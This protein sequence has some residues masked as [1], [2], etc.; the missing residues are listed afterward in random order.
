M[1]EKTKTKGGKTAP[2]DKS[3]FWIGFILI[4][5]ICVILAIF[6]EEAKGVLGK[7]FNFTTNQMGFTYIW[8]VIFMA[9][10]LVWLAFGKY[11]KVRMGGPDAR[12]EFSRLSWIAMFFCSGVADFLVIGFA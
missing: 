1:E 5:A 4:A 11:G 6:S 7:I 12:P 9:G 3:I 8:F 2:I 10:I